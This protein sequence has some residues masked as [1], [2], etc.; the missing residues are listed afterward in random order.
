MVLSSHPLVTR[1]NGAE[2]SLSP[3][4]T[5]TPLTVRLWRMA[6]SEY[7]RVIHGKSGSG[8]PIAVGVPGPAVTDEV[9]EE[10]SRL[11]EKAYDPCNWSP[12]FKV[13]VRLT[14]PPA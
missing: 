10:S 9:E 7:P 1:R 14:W 2:L 13:R 4:I 3:G 11:F 12:W 6:K 5:Y 8:L